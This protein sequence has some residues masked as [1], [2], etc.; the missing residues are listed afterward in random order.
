MMNPR[1]RYKNQI[2]VS[3]EKIRE[4][5]EA[6]NISREKLS[7]KLLLELSIDLSVSSL[8]KIESNKRPVVDYEL[9]GIA[10]ILKTDMENLIKP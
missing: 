9:W 10:K 7:S 2:N 1:K 3:G 6:N 8:E 5:R 4:T